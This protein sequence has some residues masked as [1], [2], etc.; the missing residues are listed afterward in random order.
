MMS[1]SCWGMFRVPAPSPLMIRGFKAKDIEHL[2]DEGRKPGG[3]IEFVP[4]ARGE[5]QPLYVGMYDMAPIYAV[6]DLN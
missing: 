6:D 2:A 3:I 1:I 4:L 5:S